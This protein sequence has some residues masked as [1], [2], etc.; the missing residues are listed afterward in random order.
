MEQSFTKGMKDGN[1]ICLGYFFVSFGFGILVIKSGLPA[2]VAVAIS[3]SNLTS[4]GQVA[5]VGVIAAA[6]SLVEIVLTQ[7][8]INCRYALMGLSLGQN[9]SDEF[10]V[11]HRALVSF[12]ITDEIFGVA[13]SKKE[14]LRPVYMYGL[15]VVAI[16]GW[17]GGTIIGSLGGNIFPQRVMM[18][19]GIL[20]Y[21]MFIAVIIPPI[22][23]SR[24]NLV[25]I[26]LAALI[27]CLIYFFL[28]MISSGFAIIISAVIASVVLAIAVPVE[29]DPEEETTEDPDMPGDAGAPDHDSVKENDSEAEQT[30][31]RGMPGDVEELESDLLK[32]VNSPEEEESVESS[33]SNGEMEEL[34]E[35]V[36]VPEEEEAPKPL[37]TKDKEEGSMESS[38]SNS[39]KEELK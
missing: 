37:E 30:E 13:S 21:G 4:A 8:L 7:L 31:N 12:G 36:N 1:P 16:A 19:F 27:S 24:V 39:K 14:P 10:N 15:M 20:L 18:A 11:L 32:A 33:E 34:L 9:L 17:V 22:R 23:E 38:E 3:A 6:G 28:P 5:G 2:W 26:L 25:L 29:D 35:V